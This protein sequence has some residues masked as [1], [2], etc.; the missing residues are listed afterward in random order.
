MDASHLWLESHQACT[1]TVHRASPW[2]RN[3]GANMSQTTAIFFRAVSVVSVHELH[4]LGRGVD[5]C[6]R[7]GPAEAALDAG[8]RARDR[9]RSPAQVLPLEAQRDSRARALS[10]VIKS[11]S[12]GTCGAIFVG[13]PRGNSVANRVDILCPRAARSRSTIYCAINAKMTSNLTGSTIGSSSGQIASPDLWRWLLD[14]AGGHSLA[15]VTRVA[16]WPR[17]H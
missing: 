16:S 14:F 5:I 12:S 3:R 10:A 7:R 17:A 2:T 15:P 13:T 6:R 9:P 11:M 8:A 1:V 4:E